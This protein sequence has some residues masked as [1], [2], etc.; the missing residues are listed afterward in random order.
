M[1]KKFKQAMKLFK[2]FLLLSI[3][4]TLL[5]APCLLFAQEGQI[6]NKEKLVEPWG[7]RQAL[8][9]PSLTHQASS[10]AALGGGPAVS[11]GGDRDMAP[12]YRGEGKSLT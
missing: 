2:Y 6:T 12:R 1:K 7:S 11:L 9:A 4:L 8:Q 3:I 10:I 5:A